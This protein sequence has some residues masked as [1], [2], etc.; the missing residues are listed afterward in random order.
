MD[1]D[2]LAIIDR[3]KKKGNIN[4]RERESASDIRNITFLFLIT[5]EPHQFSNDGTL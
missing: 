3:E 5:M 1:M 4:I 2:S